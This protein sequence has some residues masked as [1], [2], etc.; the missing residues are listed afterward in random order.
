[1]ATIQK[2]ITNLWFDTQAE[3]AAKYYVSIFKNSKIGR[4]MRYGKE[5]FEIPG[6]P[7]DSVM[8]IEFEI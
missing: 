8:T 7:A 3:E 4:V 2:I 6:R 5:G 1:M